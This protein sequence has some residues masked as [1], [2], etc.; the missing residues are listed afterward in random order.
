MSRIF[1]SHSSQDNA[2][3]VALRDWL[4]A[5]GW[6]DLFLDLDP[7]RGIAAG[8]R[9][10][11]ALNAEA[12]RCEAVLFLVSRPWL[13]SEWCQK[14]LHL[15]DKL[16]KRLFGVLIEDI[17]VDEVPEKIRHHFQLVN[18]A[19]G[20]DHKVFRAELPDG[21][22]EHVTLSENG[23]TK[24]KAGL[25]KAGLDPKYFV[26]PPRG[27]PDRSPYRGLKPL[28]AADAG[29]FF[30]REAPTIAALDR[31][32]GLRDAGQSSIF[33][34]LGASGAGKS[35]FLRAGLLPRLGRDDR[36]FAT[37]PV[38]RPERAALHGA[39]GLV[40]AVFAAARAIKLGRTKASIT[41]AANESGENL[42][43]LLRDL[44]DKEQAALGSS[45]Q[46]SKPP[47]LVIS[48]DQGEELFPAENASEAAKLLNHIRA[49]IE[50]PDLD[51]IVLFTIRTEAY[52]P[53]QAAR[54]L[55]GIGQKTFS[56]PPMAKGAYQT[57]IEG[58]AA[59]LSASKRPLKIEPAL[60]DALLN[61]I[62][63]GG[64]RDALPLLAF[65]LERLYLD[66]GGDGDLL[67]GEYEAIGGIKGSIEAAVEEAFR[68]A[69]ADPA[70]P[71]DRA[72]RLALL[73]RG[74]I[75]WLAGIDPETGAARR[76]VARLSEVPE[77]ARPLINHLIDARLLTT[78]AELIGADGAQTVG[79]VT[80]EPAHEALL[81]Q[82]GLL[83]EW[84]EED[85]AALTVA[86]GVR[87]AADEWRANDGHADWLAHAAGR[88]EDAEELRQRS[89]FSAYLKD[90]E[91]YLTACRAAE[92]ARR[93]QALDE[94][95]KL[96]RAQTAIARRTRIG[97]IA[98]TIL[99]I[100]AAGA[101]W[102][103]LE[104]ASRADEKSRAATA[105]EKLA[106]Q[107]A[108]S[109]AKAKTR[110]ESAL[111]T[112]TATAN[113]MLF[114]LAQ[115]FKDSSVP[116]PITRSI[117]EEAKSLLDT[118]SE[119]FPNDPEL[120][121]SRSMALA[122]LGDI[123]ALQGDIAA[124]L[125]AYEEGLGIRRDLVERVATNTQW[126]RDLSVSLDRIGDV[127]LRAG[128]APGALAAYQEGL[129]IA[130]DLVAR[131][132]TNTQWQSDLSASLDRIGDVKLQAG[133]APGALTAYQEGLGILRDLV[134]RDATNTVWQ[135]D[136]SVSLIKIGDVKR[137][138]GDTPGALAA[139]QEGLGIRR[140]LVARDATNTQWQ[141]DVSVSLDRIGDVKRRAGDA[142]G[143]LAAYQ[144]GLGI[145]RDLVARDATNT[146]W[147]RDVSVSLNKI[148]DVKLRAGDA[149]GALAAYQE[150]LGIARDLVARDATNTQWQRDVSV[151]LSKI[152]DVKLRA[153]DVPGALAAY[154]EGL[155]IARDLVAR[156]AT[157]TQWQTDLFVSL[158]KIQGIS[159][160]SDDRIRL[161]REARDILAPLEKAGKLSA[162]QAGWPDLVAMELEKLGAF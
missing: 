101:G 53:L 18:L 157:N 126:Q 79:A 134:A 30:G 75:P 35:S 94:A 26:W 28:E 159:R 19:S 63:D 144:E 58:P 123:Y 125:A 118:L 92:T 24:L 136:L 81:R 86:E 130:R 57:V 72:A 112:A 8:E 104:Q 70:V 32:R 88:L 25:A 87:R 73:R 158:W 138:A 111:R 61:D 7:E 21:H 117:L 13:A 55:E 121:R 82:W 119:N 114:S 6:D 76:R 45:A 135:R 39:T 51:V 154:E 22:E 105:A 113:R 9:W 141:R 69:D 36:N 5:E 14:E 71:R 142:P 15:A 85:F 106:E 145:A 97:A 96:A 43:S 143:A 33:V 124:A 129:G 17:P 1:L 110:A 64:G 11:R 100:L 56:L 65:T 16:N 160:K 59:R 62:E 140:D 52:E 162:Q 78:E 40:A 84:L 83:E 89:D 108:T 107:R 99:A 109:E 27:Q 49:L 34:I 146:Q 3:A 153:G 10:E 12:D 149:P 48:I 4:V 42:V 102:Y 20:R 139:Y 128:D 29:I 46:D 156:D 23:L 66:Y 44:T 50:A 116:A 38:I 80:V 31:L 150:G 120:L 54:A 74:L 37:L 90:A 47:T 132:V 67:L 137:R 148:G 131:D 41:K 93:D 127:K 103:G 161:L 122:G 152:G 68:A 77:E 133:D 95:R 98:A 91:T 147:Q 2:A 60:T 115:K 151:S 155:G